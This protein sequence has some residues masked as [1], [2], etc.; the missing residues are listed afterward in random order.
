MKSTKLDLQLLDGS[1][2]TDIDTG[3]SAA[4]GSLSVPQ[5]QMLTRGSPQPKP[6]PRGTCIPGL[7]NYILYAPTPPAFVDTI[8][9]YVPF[10]LMDVTSAW[11]T[12][13]CLAIPASALPPRV[14]RRRR[15]QGT[16]K[17]VRSVRSARP[18][19][20]PM[21]DALEPPSTN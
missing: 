6:L 5:T 9:S 12:L 10:T 14:Q 1:T 18:H 19:P 17:R 13:F 7:Y 2:L 8:M 11:L 4:S 16:G 20:R 15:S 21:T 3:Y